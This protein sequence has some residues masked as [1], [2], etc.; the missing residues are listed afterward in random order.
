MRIINSIK[1]IC[2]YRHE[3]EAS[4]KKDIAFIPTMGAIHEGHIALIKKAQTLASQVVVSIFIN[5]IQFDKQEDLDQYPRTLQKDITILE[6]NNVDILFAPDQ[7]EVFKELPKVQISIPTL[8]QSLCAIHRTKHFEGVLYIVHNLF[9]WI[10]PKYAV[11]GLKDYQQCLLVSTMTE[12]LQLGVKI[13]FSETVREKNGLAISSRNARLSQ[14]GRKKALILSQTIFQVQKKLEQQVS[15]E[16]ARKWMAA[17]LKDNQVEYANI[18]DANT[19][20]LAN[21]SHHNKQLLIAI[22]LYIRLIDNT[23]VNTS[24]HT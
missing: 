22:A 18:Y 16:Q 12:E 14:E 17:Q 2:E 3:C 5:P 6:K 8:S 11:F 1:A 10:K 21:S 13:V 4:H 23:L 15:I 9:Q 7:D 20:E 24:N 19:L